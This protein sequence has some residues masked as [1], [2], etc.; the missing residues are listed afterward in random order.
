MSSRFIKF[1]SYYKKYW[2]RFLCVM[3]SAFIASVAA[4]LIPLCMQNIARFAMASQDAGPAILYT[5]GAMLILIAI[6]LAFHFY[7]DYFGHALGARMESDLRS[8]LFAHLQR[9][10]FSFFDGNKVGALMSSLTNDLLDLTELFHHGPEDYIMN[11]VRLVGASII[12]MS[13]NARLA[14]IV[15]IFV[16]VMILMTLF[17]GR[18]LRKVSGENQERIAQINAQASDS[19]SGI[20]TVQA[21]AREQEQQ[22]RFNRA[23]EA[24]FRSRKAVY[25]N[26]SYADKTT[27]GLTQLSQVAV[28][29]FGGLAVM[30]GTLDLP[31][32]IA[33][34]MYISYL[35]EPIQ[36]LSWMITQFQTG[37]AG[38]DRVMTLMEME[39]EIQDAPDAI[40]AKDIRGEI[41]FEDVSFR[42]GESEAVLDGLSVHIPAGQ[43][44]ALAGVSGMGK[45]TLAA[46]LPRFYQPQDGTVKLDGRDVSQYQL[47][48]LRENIAWVQQDTYLF[49][50]T[51]AENIRMGNPNA[52]DEQLRQ[53][54]R[55]A[56]AEEFILRL[57]QGYDS[58]VGERGV[59]LS[60]GQ[61]Q[62]I[63]LARAL[64]KAA[65]VL[66]LDEATSALDNA[67][68][69]RV[70]D[71]LRALRKD[72]TTLVIAH[73]L[74]TIRDADRILVLDDGRIA[75]DGTHETLMRQ[76]GLY[77]ALYRRQEENI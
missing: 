41:D 63:G 4:L 40:A 25:L 55:M 65:P 26:E 50:G 15:L 8:E 22:R 5:G 11:L 69:Q 53:A 72:Q 30:G 44:V 52:T 58:L 73:R 18:R 45:S 17:W 19:L 35:T 24:F 27:L 9:Q 36:K 23:G 21:F 2:R 38:F 3:L 12:L 64:V 70:H 1:L 62:R 16:P 77:A 57:P 75:E 42:Y 20:R 71:A 74:S 34:T 43:F 49:D 46:L 29:L 48:S 6:Q 10:S 13:I 47:R 32:L 37:M 67:S 54:A 66:I 33:F 59:R 39:S 76:D 28:I 14:L 51:I 60:G 7:F 56:D 31:G 61:R 68:Q